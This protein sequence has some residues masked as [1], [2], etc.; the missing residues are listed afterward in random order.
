MDSCKIETRYYSLIQSIRFARYGTFGDSISSLLTESLNDNS[1][2]GER[3]LKFSSVIDV[4]GNLTSLPGKG[5][6][7]VDINLMALV[8][9]NSIFNL[10]N[11]KWV[12]ATGQF[13]GKGFDLTSVTEGRSNMYFGSVM[14]QIISLLNKS[15]VREVWVE[16]DKRGKLK[17]FRDTIKFL[18]LRCEV[19]KANPRKGLAL[20]Y[21]VT[22]NFVN[23]SI[24]SKSV[25]ISEI[26]DS[27]RDKEFTLAV[28]SGDFEKANELRENNDK[29]YARSI[30]QHDGPEL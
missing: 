17:D 16:G 18:V 23:G 4:D 21:E 1:E 26:E 19:P 28:I 14:N 7:D 15:T 3:L 25:G 13:K 22:V 5:F 30:P 12:I 20:I 27:N 9:S 2:F 10:V 8:K 29:H 6:R 24:S 11:R